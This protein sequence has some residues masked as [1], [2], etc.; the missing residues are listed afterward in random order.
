MFEDLAADEFI[1]V[2]YISKDTILSPILE[3]VVLNDDWI[4]RRKLLNNC[5]YTL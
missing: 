4:I 1:F 5:K 3:M 2:R